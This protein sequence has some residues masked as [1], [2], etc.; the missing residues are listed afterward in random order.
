MWAF[1]SSVFTLI[2]SPISQPSPVYPCSQTQRSP[3]SVTSHRPCKH[4]GLWHEASGSPCRLHSAPWYP[5]SQSQRYVCASNA[6]H[7]PF[8]HLD[9]NGETSLKTVTLL[10]YRK[11]WRHFQVQCM[12]RWTNQ[13]H[14]LPSH[15]LTP[16]AVVTTSAP[17]RPP[18]TGWSQCCPIQPG[19]QWH[20]GPC[21]RRHAYCLDKAKKKKYID[22]L[23]VCLFYSVS[24]KVFLLEQ[25]HLERMKSFY[26]QVT[27]LLRQ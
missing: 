3:S 11:P 17:V 18:I 25:Q 26:R 16:V 20:W 7:T 15:T 22:L 21:E 2:S 5:S 10:F 27:C 6:T 13:T 8:T 19:W 1:A 23:L 9:L 24:L 4:C 12:M 14:L